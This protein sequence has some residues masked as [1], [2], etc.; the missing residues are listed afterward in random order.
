MLHAYVYVILF[1]HNFYKLKKKRKE[2]EEKHQQQQLCSSLNS[3]H[4]FVTTLRWISLISSSLN[5]NYLL[6]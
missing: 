4:D 6:H 5:A 1:T 3:N 2:K